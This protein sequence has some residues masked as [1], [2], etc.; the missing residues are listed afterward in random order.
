VADKAED[1]GVLGSLY[2][3]VETT[4]F[5]PQPSIGWKRI[6]GVF[7]PADLGGAA[8]NWNGVGFNPSDEDVIE[9]EE[10]ASTK[11]IEDKPSGLKALFSG[12]N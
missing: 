1:I 8:A 12:K 6:N 11:E 9:A 2:E 10:I 5:R 4:N 7:Q 3:I